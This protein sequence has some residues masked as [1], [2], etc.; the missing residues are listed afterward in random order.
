[1]GFIIFH[2]INGGTSGVTSL[3]LQSLKTEFHKKLRI[4][5]TICPSPTYSSSIVEC[6]NSCFGICNLN[7]DCDF[8]IMI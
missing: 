3:V 1:M 2:S 7:K 8:N 6:Y 4:S 5:Y